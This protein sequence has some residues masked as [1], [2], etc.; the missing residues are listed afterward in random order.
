MSRAT[1]VRL[2][3]L[4]LAVVAA[5]SGGC[6]PKQPT[7]SSS[8]FVRETGTE[9]IAVKDAWRD[10][11]LRNYAG[12]VLVEMRNAANVRFIQPVTMT[13][14]RSVR[15]GQVELLVFGEVDQ[16]NLQYNRLRHPFSISWTQDG[17]NWRV[18]E[19]RIG[20]GTTA[21]EPP[22]PV[23]ANPVRVPTTT[24]APADVAPPAP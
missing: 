13:A 17:G 8:D 14:I 15:T 1:A 18:T 19:R 9:R 5:L 10:F 6:E 12:E 11:A 20:P 4:P 7:T 22:R 21:P 16:T 23:D 24:T 3:L 2:S